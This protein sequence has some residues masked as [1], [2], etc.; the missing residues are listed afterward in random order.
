[1]APLFYKL[2]LEALN[3]SIFKGFFNRCNQKKTEYLCIAGNNNCSI[4]LADRTSC[5]SCRLQKCIRMGMSQKA[6][7]FG[8]HISK[9]YF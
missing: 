6:I 5:K 1:M 8:K 3:S 4:L 2:F 9:F 7:K